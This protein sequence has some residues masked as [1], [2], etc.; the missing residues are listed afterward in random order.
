MA[1]DRI[2]VEDLGINTGALTDCAG[3]PG[4]ASVLG[5]D[6]GGTLFDEDGKGDFGSKEMGV[7]CLV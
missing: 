2:G 5:G 3:R 4:V 6:C 1:A 7:R